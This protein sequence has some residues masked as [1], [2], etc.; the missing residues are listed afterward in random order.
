[1]APKVGVDHFPCT[2]HIW[3]VYSFPNMAEIKTL[4]AVVLFAFVAAPPA[5]AQDEEGEGHPAAWEA[6]YKAGAF[7]FY[8][9]ASARFRYDTNIFLE[10]NDADPAFMELLGAG[11]GVTVNEPE[12]ALIANHE[13]LQYWHH[14]HEGANR[15][16]HNGSGRFAWKPC[17]LFYLKLGASFA[18]AAQPVDSATINLVEL[19]QMGGSI[20]FGFDLSEIDSKVEAEYSITELTT[21]T[22]AIE[23]FEHHKWL[24][25]IRFIHTCS[26]DITTVLEATRGETNFD[27]GLKMDNIIEQIRAA[28]QWQASDEVAAFGALAYLDR[29][30]RHNSGVLGP[31][32]ADY[33]GILFETGVEW[34]PDNDNRLS[35]VIV[36]DVQESI[37][38]NWMRRYAG[39]VAYTRVLCPDHTITVAGGVEFGREAVNTLQRIKQ[40]YTAQAA[41]TWQLNPALTWETSVLYRTKITNDD[42]GEYVD[43]Q[44]TTGLVFQFGDPLWPEHVE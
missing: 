19:Q 41:Y 31:G 12:V 6:G 1:M 24:G 20:T 38:S 44:F 40:R 39:R 14:Q 5:F 17:D 11:L 28:M 22:A 7:T 26:E 37:L 10:G 8:P 43:W 29:N 15:L 4:I 18:R 30:Y 34:R 21:E 9:R 36:K 23:L 16:E 33:T 27:D 2:S 32:N 35:I 25:T 42:L 13:V 3:G